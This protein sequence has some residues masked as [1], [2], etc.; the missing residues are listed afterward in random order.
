MYEHRPGIC[1][2]LALGSPRA[3]AAEVPTFETEEAKVVRVNRSPEPTA[4]P[5]V[6]TVGRAYVCP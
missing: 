6:L 3:Q 4:D 1:S 5:R 2:T